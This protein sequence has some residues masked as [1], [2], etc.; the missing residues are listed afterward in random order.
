MNLALFNDVLKYESV[1][2]I[3]INMTANG[4]SG[5]MSVKVNDDDIIDVCYR[6]G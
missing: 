4:D 2:T 3:H 1:M 5:K 6:R